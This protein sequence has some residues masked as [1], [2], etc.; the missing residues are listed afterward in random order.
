MISSGDDELEQS[1]GAARPPAQPIAITAT[2]EQGHG[3]PRTNAAPS[4]VATI[5]RASP[6]RIVLL[7][8]DVLATARAI[9]DAWNSGR[10]STAEAASLAQA[11][12]QVAIKRE[13]EV[14]AAA[15]PPPAQPIATTAAGRAVTELEQGQGEPRTAAVPQPAQSFATAISA[16][17][18][19]WDS[20]RIS[21]TEAAVMADQLLASVPHRRRRRRRSDR[22]RHCCYRNIRKFD[23]PAWWSARPAWRRWIKRQSSK[24][25]RRLGRRF[26]EDAPTKPYKARR[27]PSR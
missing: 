24:R 19:A 21:T 27:W 3:E 23:V 14:R 7:R 16:I 1:Q 6:A 8:G 26:G 12:N 4:P 22:S 9:G 13:D 10:I 11:L 25:M 2:P 17:C 18:D 20:G 5:A 15:A